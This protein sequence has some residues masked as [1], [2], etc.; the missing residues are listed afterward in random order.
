MDS[1]NILQK[2]IEIITQKFSD[3]FFKIINIETD[4]KRISKIAEKYEN[5]LTSLINP[6]ETYVKSLEETFWGFKLNPLAETDLRILDINFKLFDPISYFEKFNIKT[7]ISENLKKCINLE[8]GSLGKC[9]LYYSPETKSF[10]LD[11]KQGNIGKSHLPDEELIAAELHEAYS[12]KFTLL[13][14]YL[15][16]YGNI[17]FG[18]AKFIANPK[19][20]FIFGG[21]NSFSEF[22]N[23]LVNLCFQNS[24]YTPHPES[25]SNKFSLAEYVSYIF[26]YSGQFEAIKTSI[27]NIQ[28]EI[29]EIERSKNYVPPVIEEGDNVPF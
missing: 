10:I 6:L 13:H 20:L 25:Y 28:E 29:K 9:V 16:P 19:G 23:E 17:C 26:N 22:S 12:D 15:V 21:S 18:G 7:G 14:K 3:L 5:E 4:E 11:G 8:T 27:E 2:K 1:E 24:G